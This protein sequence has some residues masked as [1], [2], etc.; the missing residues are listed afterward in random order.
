MLS[1]LTVLDVVV[2]EDKDTEDD[3]DEPTDIEGPVAPPIDMDVEAAAAT[4][5]L[6]ELEVP[7]TTD[8]PLPLLIVR[9]IASAMIYSDSKDSVTSSLT[10]KDPVRIVV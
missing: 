4:T 7:I 1:S 9:L 2:F 8:G 6:I 3:G 10:T 5:E